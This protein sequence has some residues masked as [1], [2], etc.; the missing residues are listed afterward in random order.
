MAKIAEVAGVGAGS[1]YLYY[2]NKANI[3][4]QIFDNLWQE[5]AHKQ[6][7]MIARTDLTPLEKL[8]GMIDLVF[9]MFAS[10]SSLALVYVTYTGKLGFQFRHDF[11]L[12]LIQDFRY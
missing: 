5:L 10:N 9:D 11:V 12:D 2:K 7:K 4:S 1:L 8:D 6:E 3:L